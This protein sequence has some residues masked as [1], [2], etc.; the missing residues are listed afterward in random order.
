[1]PADL[2]GCTVATELVR[3]TEAYFQRL[4]VGVKMVSNGS[5]PVDQI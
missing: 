3:A 4:G 5:L 2:E 1:M